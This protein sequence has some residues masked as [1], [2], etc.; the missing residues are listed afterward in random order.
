MVAGSPCMCMAAQATPSSAAT[1]PLAA[2]T[3]L[4]S[5]APAATAARATAALRVSIETRAPLG[6]ERLDH[7]DDPPQLL[8]LATG[9]APGRVDSPPTSSQSAPSASRAR[10]WAMAAAWSSNCPPSENESGVTLMTPITSGRG[11]GTSAV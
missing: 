5:V 2:P 4:S 6:G 9:A 8:R 3:S 11:W 10:P 7:G 1:A